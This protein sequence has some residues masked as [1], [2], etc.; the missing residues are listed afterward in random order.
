MR[1]GPAIECSSALRAEDSVAENHGTECCAT[2]LNLLLNQLRNQFRI[3]RFLQVFDLIRWNANPLQVHEQ[4]IPE[5]FT[6]LAFC[7]V[8]IRQQLLS[9]LQR[10]IVLVVVI[11]ADYR[12]LVPREVLR[13]HS[14]VSMG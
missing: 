9:P 12:L 5:F 8:E 1:Q 6:L 3:L 14:Q 13:S 11:I 4:A 10:N 2:L 7:K